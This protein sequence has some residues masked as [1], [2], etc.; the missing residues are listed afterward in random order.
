M[1]EA[2][3]EEIVPARFLQRWKPTADGPKANARV[4]IEGFKHCDVLNENLQKESPTLS[5]LGRM[6]VMIWAVHRQW[7]IWCADVKSA[8]MQANS[9]DESTRIY[10]K[11]PAEMMMGLKEDEILKATKPAFGDVRAPRQWFESADAFLVHEMAFVS[12]P[13]DRCVY[14]SLREATVDDDEFMVFERDGGKWI[15][16]G[17]LGLHVDDFI[18]A[19]EGIKCLRDVSK[20]PSGACE[21]FQHRLYHL[22]KR[23]RFGSWDFGDKMRFCGAEV[24]QSND[25]MTATVSL[26]EYVN[27]IKPIS[28]EKSRK[29]MVNDYCN[30]KEPRQLRALVRCHGL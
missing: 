17:I 21:K 16:D 9:I 18:G 2:S 11:P 25:L 7:K 26:Q 23:F 6:L 28:M 3:P 29:T 27:K 5:R 8:F 15:V 10:V 13:L 30:E 14:L 4:I 24:K 12:H 19:G 22:S 20:D 1:S